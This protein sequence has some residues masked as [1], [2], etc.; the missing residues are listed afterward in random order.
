MATEKQI[1]ANKANAKLS[2]GPKTPEGKAKAAQNP[3]THG[4]LARAA[5]LETED[6]TEFEEHRQRISC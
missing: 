3:I 1:Q 6:V 5:I 4:V 2:T